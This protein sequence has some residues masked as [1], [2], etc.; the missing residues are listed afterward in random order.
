MGVTLAVLDGAS[1]VSKS[2]M[3]Q[4]SLEHFAGGLFK[5]SLWRKKVIVMKNH[6]KGQVTFVNL[7]IILLIMFVY[8]A[9]LPVIISFIN[10]YAI[11]AIASFTAD[12]PTKDLLTAIIQLFPLV[13]A[14]MIL[15]S[16]LF[17]AIPRPER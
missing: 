16:G 11:P 5:K 3:P 13:L 10:S 15:A 8:L 12:Q 6:K 9:F 17:Y 14:V 2:K 7:L 1:S 4:S